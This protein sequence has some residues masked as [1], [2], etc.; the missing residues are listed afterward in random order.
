MGGGGDAG[1]GA[2]SRNRQGARMDALMQV[3]DPRADKFGTAPRV[4]RRSVPYLPPLK[5]RLPP[6]ARA[7]ALA[8][9][10]ALLMADL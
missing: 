5:P 10:R 3:E 1:S 9:V 4:R 6:L 7:L 8:A 2:A